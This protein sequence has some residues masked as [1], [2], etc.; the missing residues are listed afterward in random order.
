M[1]IWPA[2][3]GCRGISIR[4]VEIAFPIEDPSPA[5]RNH[6]RSAAAFPERPRQGARAAARRHLR[7]PEA[8]RGRAAF[9]GAVAFPRTLASARR[10]KLAE[11]QTRRQDHACLRSAPRRNETREEKKILVIDIGGIEREADDFTGRKRR[12]FD[13]G[14]RLTPEAAG[15]RDQGNASSDWEFRRDRARVSRP[16]AKRAD[17]D[18]PET[19]R[20][21]LGGIRF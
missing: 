9:A 14:P 11:A 7:P 4:R 16:G 2:P 10:S 12:K 15:Q 5:R 21:R 20:Q 13:S 6:Q 19:S 1:S 18:G 8:G 3:T 17:H